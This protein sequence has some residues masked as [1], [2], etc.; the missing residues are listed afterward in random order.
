L[1]IKERERR[2]SAVIRRSLYFF[3]EVQRE[4]GK[5]EKEEEVRASDPSA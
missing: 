3:T 2:E 5:R 4:G 1:P